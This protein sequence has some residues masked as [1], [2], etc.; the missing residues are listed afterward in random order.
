MGKMNPVRANISPFRIRGKVVDGKNNPIPFATV[1]I[2]ESNAGIAADSNG[3]FELETFRVEKQVSLEVSSVGFNTAEIMINEK[4]DLTEG[5]VIQL[6]HNIDLPEVI[7]NSSSRSMVMGASISGTWLTGRKEAKE[8]TV[9]SQVR[10]YPNPVQR[11]GS[12][13]IEFDSGQEERMKLSIVNMS[14][15]VVSMKTKNILKGSNRITVNT[16]AV[17]PAGI[18]IV[19]LTNEKGNVIKKEKLIVQ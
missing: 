16:E 6:S 4:T 7:I 3:L 14:G 8:E 15:I 9:L 13:N 12:F 2:K 5:L 19:H 11:N 10:L 18:Y 17:W 1:M